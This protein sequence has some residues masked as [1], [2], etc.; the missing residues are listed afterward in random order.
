MD[1]FHALSKNVIKFFLKKFG[2]FSLLK[3]I[4]KGQAED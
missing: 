2:D 3:A 1:N 4:K